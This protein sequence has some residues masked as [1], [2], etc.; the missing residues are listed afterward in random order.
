MARQ[1]LIRAFVALLLVV[2]ALGIGGYSGFLVGRGVPF[3]S[4]D[5]VYCTAGHTRTYIRLLED[6]RSS[7][8]AMAEG[9]METTIDSGVIQLS[10]APEKSG[11]Q[12]A[13]VNETLAVV[14]DHRKKHPW[15][16]SSAEL[17]EQVN[18]ALATVR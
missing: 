16:G 2:P 6:L 18:R 4:Q 17:S 9:L 5:S 3:Q 10:S 14:R 11:E 1:A 12:T 15:K 7:D 8:I 13:L